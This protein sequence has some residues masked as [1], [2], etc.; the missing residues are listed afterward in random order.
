M[1]SPI[2]RYTGIWNE[3]AWQP[4]RVPDGIPLLAIAGS[5]L[6]ES[7]QKRVDLSSP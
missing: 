6:R 2:Q 4:Y 3:R 7:V 1:G 5:V